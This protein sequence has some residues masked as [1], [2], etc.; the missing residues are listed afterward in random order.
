[1]DL[2]RLWT[3][4]SNIGLIVLSTASIYA[5][6]IVYTRIAGLRSLASMS[7][8]DFAATVAIGSTI[9]TVANLGT[10]TAQ[11]LVVLGLLFVLQAVVGVARRTRVAGV[12]DNQPLLLMAGAEVLHDNL[13]R[14]RVTENELMAQLRLRGVVHL[15]Q[16]RAVV[17][18]STGSVSVLTSGDPPDAALLAGVREAER[19]PLRKGSDSPAGPEPPRRA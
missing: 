17:L 7:S 19:I 14:V 3:S 13:R 10:P 8:F 2:A 15:Q 16:V 4:W 6:V 12:V 9:A 11:G 18:E 1:V 5:S